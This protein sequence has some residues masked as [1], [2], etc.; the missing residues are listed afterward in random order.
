MQKRCSYRASFFFFRPEGQNFPMPASYLVHFC[1]FAVMKIHLKLLWILAPC[2]MLSVTQAQRHFL[3]QPTGKFYVGTQNLF[4]TD[5]SRKEKL[6]FRSGDKRSL[7]VKIWYPSD[8]RKDTPNLYLKD[9]DGK[10]LWENYR[11]FN[12]DRGFFDTLK[13]YSSFAYEDVPVSR[14]KEKFPII[15]FSPG[16]YFGL[17]DYYTALMENLASNGYIVVSITH[18]YDQVITK[19]A[20]GNVVGLKKLRVTR[21]YL[22]WKKV[23]FMHKKNPDTANT[24]QVNRIL[25]AYLRGMKIFDRS[26]RLWVKDVQFMMDTL[27]KLNDHAV[28]DRWYGKIDF[29]KVATLGQSVGGA[30]AGQL[31]YVDS[32]VKAGVNLDCFQFGDL[33]RHE[34][35]KPFLLLQSETY[36]LWAIANN[37]IYANTS[38]FHSFT[39]PG[40]RHFIFSDCCLFPS[41]QN[42][43]MR[44]L[45]GEGNKMENVQKINAYLVDFYNHYLNGAPFQQAAFQQTEIQPAN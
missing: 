24:R 45:I 21:A 1:L 30:V 16:F 28:D 33:Y 10:L 37:I 14:R 2:M 7:Q 38:P 3:P 17:D 39:L 29:S 11:I 27:Q 34:M 31:C 18:P 23:E 43:K 25:K 22:Q 26:V 19:T 13:T 15:F 35:K 41:E 32:R 9:Y 4:F 12:D 44:E 5:S 6:T 40:T 8:E 20:D 36:P 42:K